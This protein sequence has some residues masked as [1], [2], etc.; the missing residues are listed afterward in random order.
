MNDFRI[1]SSKFLQKYSADVSKYYK[2]PLKTY[3][4][5]LHKTELFIKL[6]CYMKHKGHLM[7]IKMFQKPT[8]R[9]DA[10][11]QIITYMYMYSVKS[12][13]KKVWGV[14]DKRIFHQF[15]LFKVNINITHFSLLIKTA[16][17]KKVDI[18]LTIFKLSNIF[19]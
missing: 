3:K 11:E 14:E 9:I 13:K 2:V 5:K 4:I 16:F 8:K 15:L 10:Q 12:M 18:H 17:S 19:D 6:W 7:Y 1:Y